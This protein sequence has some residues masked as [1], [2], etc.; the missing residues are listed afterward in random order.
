MNIGFLFQEVSNQIW[1][2]LF[3]YPLLKTC[4]KFNA[5]IKCC[6]KV[7]WE[8][9]CGKPRYNIEYEGNEFDAE[10]H[11]RHRASNLKGKTIKRFVWPGLV[12]VST[13][14]CVYRAL[15]IT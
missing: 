10:R 7:A 6:V 15:V 12:E 13:Q 14:N 3:D 4:K 2:T 1:Q 5:F 9:S 11:K 8:L